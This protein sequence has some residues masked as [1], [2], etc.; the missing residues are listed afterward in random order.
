M[1]FFHLP[2]KL[3]VKE[4]C[5]L[6][7]PAVISDTLLGLSDSLISVIL[8]HMGKAVV[9]SYAIVTVVTKVCT[10]AT[11]G[12][13]TAAGVQMGQTVGK[14]DFNQAHKEGKSFLLISGI[15]GI[16][17]GVLVLTLGTLSIG[18]YNIEASTYKIAA[19]MMAASAVV[20][21]FQCT[22]SVTTKGILRGDGNTKFLMVADVIF[23]WCACLPL[24]YL[25]GL[26]WN[27]SPFWVLIALRIDY[28]IKAMWM[29]FRLKSDKWIHK[30]KSTE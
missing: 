15:I 20:S 23:Q 21:L 30:V 29:S 14:G 19:E 3:L 10:V 11:L 2:Q 4:F 18:L 13:A 9:S 25:T 17:S 24:G 28:I 22:Q 7:L 12:V 27:L 8:G 5:R 6:G 16:I 1:V 26:V